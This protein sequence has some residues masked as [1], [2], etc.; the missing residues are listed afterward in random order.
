MDTQTR[1]RQPQFIRVLSQR[2]PY[3]RVVLLQRDLS[4]SLC[5]CVSVCLSVSLLLPMLLYVGLFSLEKR[6]LGQA[7]YEFEVGFAFGFDILRHRCYTGFLCVTS[8]AVLDLA[9]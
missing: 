9:L 2:F 6:K 8:L 1:Q 3:L 5:V 4:L 7:L